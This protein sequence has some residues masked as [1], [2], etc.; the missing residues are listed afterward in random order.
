MKRFVISLM[1]ALF[2][3]TV[4]AQSIPLLDKVPDH[5]VEFDYVYYLAKD[6]KPE[7]EV[8]SGKVTVEDNAYAMTGLGLEVYS[9]GKTRVSVDRSASEVLLETVE[10]EDLFTNPALFIGAYRQYTDR[11]KVNRSGKDYL[12]V[13]LTLDEDAVCRFH[14]TNIR[15]LDKQ[16]VSDFAFDLSSVGKDFLVTDLR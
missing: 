2:A 10:K 6:G 1:A 15:F 5:R 13:S 14:L 12:D 8:T 4:S 7:F 16:G 3:L 9:D 11:I